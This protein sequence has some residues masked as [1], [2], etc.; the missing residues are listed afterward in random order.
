[1]ETMSEDAPAAAVATSR[2]YGQYCP[3]TRAVEVLGERWSI[4][5]L[6]ELLVGATRFNEVARGLP[7]LSRTLLSKRLRQLQ[8]A[9]LIERL[10]GRYLLT[11]AGEDL[12]PFVF[13]LGDWGARWA[14]G[15]PRPDELDSELLAWWV[16]TRLDQ[17]LLPD[18]RF[19]LHLH[20]HGVPDPGAADR[21]WI[22][23]D[24][25]GPSV[26][27]H[28]PGFDVDLTV[29]ADLATFYEIWVRRRDLASELRRGTVSASGPRAMT[30]M[31][32]RLLLLS[33]VGE[34]GVVVQ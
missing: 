5:V 34:H 4:L 13:G 2:A 23:V 14:F 21:F 20:F 31:L 7:G 8:A 19:V 15:E 3:I 17:T 12:R 33:P 32:P 25:A 18:R 1:M 9:G 28:D 24:Q 29:V 26:C 10:D 6:R 27:L 30:R 16:H 11:E 22:V